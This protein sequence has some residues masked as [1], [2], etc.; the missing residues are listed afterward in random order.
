MEVRENRLLADLHHWA[1]P[2]HP[3]AAISTWA[4][5]RSFLKGL[6]QVE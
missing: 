2:F 3:T 6:G 4:K 5:P 1:R